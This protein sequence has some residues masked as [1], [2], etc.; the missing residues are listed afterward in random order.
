MQTWSH[1]TVQMNQKTWS[2]SLFLVEGI[3]LVDFADR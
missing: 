3:L 1:L 2:T